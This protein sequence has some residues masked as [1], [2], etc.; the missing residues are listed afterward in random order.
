ML[1][2]VEGEECMDDATVWQLADEPS[3][4][5]DAPEGYASK[6]WARMERIQ[7]RLI[8]SH[9]YRCNQKADRELAARHNLTVEHVTDFPSWHFPGETKLVVWYRAD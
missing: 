3:K 1:G 8:A 5:C 6:Q 4:L 7:N 2:A 9:V